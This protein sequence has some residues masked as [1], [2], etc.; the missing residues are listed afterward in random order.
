MRILFASVPVLLAPLLPPDPAPVLQGKPWIRYT[1]DNTA[2]GA[3]GVKI[4]DTKTDGRPDI[5]T[6]WEEGGLI[7]AYFNPSRVD[8]RTPWPQVTVGRVAS[9]EDAV[10]ADLDRDLAFDVVS[11]CEGKERTVYI[12][13]APKSPDRF[14][15]SDAW[16]TTPIAASQGRMMW[17]F[18][19]PM[20]VDG[21]NGPDLVAGGKGPGAEIGWFEAPANARD[22][23]AWKW[24][25]LRPVGWI[26]S[27]YTVDMDADGDLDI[28]FSDRKGERTGVY[29]LENPRVK[30]APFDAAA[31]WPEHAVGSTG[32]EVM[33]I[34][35]TDADGD[36][37]PDVA[38]AVKPRDIQIHHRLSRDGTRW[39]T[40]EMSLP[41]AATGT[42]KSV[43]IT[44][45]NA[46]GKLD[47]IYSAEQTPPGASGVVWRA[48]DDSALHDISGPEGIKYD[49]IELLDLDGDQDLD[50]VTTE[51]NFGADSK[52]LGLIWYENPGR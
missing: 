12:H 28:L 21:R 39:K 52:G 51:E 47:V 22:T 49:F 4:T 40:A 41:A 23:A 31:A 42:A 6:A 48:L 50:V 29:W 44:D 24:H 2:S 13:W 1:I 32:R 8:S 5:A 16:T 33:F 9:P 14:W 15:Q 35:Y 11:A 34:D 10:F 30:G 17:M 18:V 43:R 7:R 46:D 3:D 19:Q 38:A 36:G 25:P 20:Q 37:L 27:I 26:M 45:V